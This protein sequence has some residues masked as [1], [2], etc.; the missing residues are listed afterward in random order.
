MGHI[1]TDLYDFILM[2]QYDLNPTCEHKLSTLIICHNCIK[3]KRVLRIELLDLKNIKDF[4]PYQLEE[5]SNTHYGLNQEAKRKI[6]IPHAASPKGS[7]I[8]LCRVMKY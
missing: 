3:K 7:L 6:K 2:S 4:Y 1:R 5:W 8:R